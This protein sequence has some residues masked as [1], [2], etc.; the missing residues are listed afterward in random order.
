MTDEKTTHKEMSD[1]EAVQ[2]FLETL[3][4]SYWL[5][6]CKKDVNAELLSKIFIEEGFHLSKK[7]LENLGF[8]GNCAKTAITMAREKGL[9]SYPEWRDQMLKQAKEELDER[10]NFTALKLELWY[11]RILD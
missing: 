11:N 9:P 7:Q 8:T 4:Y 10:R 1:E 6:N 2:E 3:T 5:P